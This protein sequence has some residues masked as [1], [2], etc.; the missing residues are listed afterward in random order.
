MID[1]NNADRPKQID[2][3]KKLAKDE[4]QWIAQ[5]KIEYNDKQFSSQ[6][7]VMY[8]KAKRTPS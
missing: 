8:K 2:E 3:E 5:W 4:K 7:V 6:L 1:K